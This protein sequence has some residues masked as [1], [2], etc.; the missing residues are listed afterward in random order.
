[1]KVTNEYFYFGKI[2]E[3][4]LSE[5]DFSEDWGKE[6]YYRIFVDADKEQ[7]EVESVGGVSVAIPFKYNFDMVNAMQK[8]QH[9]II[10][11]VVGAPNQN[12]EPLS[13]QIGN[14]TRAT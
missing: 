3:E 2:P 8:V 1:M 11:S 7:F 10:A 4:F 6:Y 14:A 13:G 12:S 9:E 5:V